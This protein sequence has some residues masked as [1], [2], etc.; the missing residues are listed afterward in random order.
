MLSSHKMGLFQS[1]EESE[2]SHSSLLQQRF[3][4]NLLVVCGNISFT[5]LFTLDNARHHFFQRGR[6]QRAAATPQQ[7]AWFARL[8]WNWGREAD[9]LVPAITGNRRGGGVELPTLTDVGKRWW[10]ELGW[11]YHPCLQSLLQ[12]MPRNMKMA[13]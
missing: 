12:E 4:S 8:P 5:A 13:G 9:N 7:E 10:E 2:C 6:S 11:P 1:L 3:M